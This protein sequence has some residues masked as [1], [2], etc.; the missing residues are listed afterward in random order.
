MKKRGVL[1]VII[2]LVDTFGKKA[3]PDLLVSCFYYF[4]FL[5]RSW[6]RTSLKSGDWSNRTGKKLESNRCKGGS[7][8]VV[9]QVFFS[10]SPSQLS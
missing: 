8:I 9:T 6:I 10:K 2:S 4:S 3:K 5:S 7:C 1:E